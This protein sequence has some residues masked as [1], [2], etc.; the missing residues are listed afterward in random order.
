[1]SVRSS[2]SVFKAPREK[3]L[4]PDNYDSCYSA[5]VANRC[6]AKNCVYKI[7]CRH[8]HL[9]YI[10]ESSRTIGSRLREH[11]RMQKQ[12]V[13]V[14]LASRSRFPSLGDISWKV[15]HNNIQAFSTRKVMEALE[16][17]KPESS[18]MNGCVGRILS[19]D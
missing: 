1:M 19:I 8:C 7:N 2:A 11:V 17:R 9:K 12:T 16:I 14:H 18:I 4:C 15:L 13:Y 5:E 10:G 3:Q 6:L